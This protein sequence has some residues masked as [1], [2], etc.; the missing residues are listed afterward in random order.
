MCACVRVSVPLV[1]W[2][3]RTLRTHSKDPSPPEERCE[4]SASSQGSSA[5][6]DKKKKTRA[7]GCLFTSSHAVDT[8]LK[9]ERK[10]KPADLQHGEASFH[11]HLRGDSAGIFRLGTKLRKELQHAARK[12][13]REPTPSREPSSGIARV[14]C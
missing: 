5:P 14:T 1:C 6:E 8:E 13:R 9:P 2:S 3:Q 12:R 11:R 4:R 10:R 7:G